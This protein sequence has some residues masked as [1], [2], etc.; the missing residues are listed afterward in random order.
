LWMAYLTMLYRFEGPN[1]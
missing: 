1:D